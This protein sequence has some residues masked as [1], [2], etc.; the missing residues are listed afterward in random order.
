MAN[1]FIDSVGHYDT[2][3]LIKKYPGLT[4]PSGPITVE[5]GAGPRGNNVIRFGAAGIQTSYF[6]RTFD[7]QPTWILGFRYKPKE[8]S[9]A[10]RIVA[11]WDGLSG[12]SQIEL[13]ILTDGR[14]VITRNGTL[15]G[16][17]AGNPVPAGVWSFLE[18][19]VTIHPSTGSAAARIDNTQVINLTNV[20][21][22][23]SSN[24]SASQIRWGNK[25]AAITGPG[26]D[27]LCD[28]YVHDG[29]GAADN[30]Y[31]GDTEIDYLAPNGNGSTIQFTPVG[32]ATNYQNVDETTPNTADYNEDNIVGH[33]DYYIYPDITGSP[34]IKCV[35][36]VALA[37]KDDGNDR[38]V[39][40]ATLVAATNYDG[41]AQDVPA[42]S[43]YLLQQWPDNPNTSADWTAAGVNGA[44]F[45]PR[46]HT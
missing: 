34:I 20:N 11:L 19:K 36:G 31:W 1:R 29:T 2:S 10:G 42:S 33:R 12:T 27:D 13:G 21:T 18:L 32:S 45:G 15:L 37:S 39:Q 7:D 14:L 9:V 46:V 5:A 24:D 43:S 25:G 22:R 35:Q 38:K 44:E 17:A 30:N 26:G 41:A 28:F 23:A 6:A 8:T 40:L 16:A 3:N 4:T